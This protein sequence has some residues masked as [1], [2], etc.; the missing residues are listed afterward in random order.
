MLRSKLG[1]T[2]RRIAEP[3][4]CI[5]KSFKKKKKIRKHNKNVHVQKE[6]ILKKWKTMLVKNARFEQF[7]LAFQNFASNHIYFQVMVDELA[8]VLF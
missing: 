6:I 4:N 7:M 1:K 3:W 8:E 2:V 5:I